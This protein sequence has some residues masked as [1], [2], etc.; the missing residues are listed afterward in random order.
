MDGGTVD[1][2]PLVLWPYGKWPFFRSMIYVISKK[3]NVHS[4]LLK[5]HRITKDI[6]GTDLVYSPPKR[7]LK[8]INH[9]ASRKLLFY[10]LGDDYSGISVWFITGYTV[11]PNNLHSI[12]SLWHTTG[13]TGIQW[14]VHLLVNRGEAWKTVILPSTTVKNCDST[15]KNCDLAIETTK[16]G[17]V[18]VCI[19]MPTPNI[20]SL[21][22][23]FSV[24]Y[25]E[26]QQYLKKMSW[27]G[28]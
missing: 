2:D 14:G 24:I 15:M 11:I 21:I 8:K 1:M 17:F 22:G 16:N 13:I 10:S 3:M 26:I 20:T 19:N 18:C 27:H 4:R 6:M 9:Q 23:N 5:Y 25:Q 12:G 7:F 28:G